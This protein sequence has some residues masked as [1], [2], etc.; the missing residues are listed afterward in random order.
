V[1][2]TI[3]RLIHSK[4]VQNLKLCHSSNCHSSQNHT[5]YPSLTSAVNRSQ[6]LY[7]A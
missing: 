4:N 3:D 5:R 7:C 2:Y 1:K 6:R